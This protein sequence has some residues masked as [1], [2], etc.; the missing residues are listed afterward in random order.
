MAGQTG[1][2]PINVLF[3][4]EG[5]DARSLMAEAILNREG[6]G[7]FVGFSA[8]PD[9]K[10][11][12]NEHAAAVL[13]SVNYKVDALKPKSWE[14]F[15][16]PEAPRMGFVFSLDERIRPESEPAWPGD[17]LCAV[18]AIP[19][20]V[21]ADGSLANVGLAYADAFRMINNRI[22]LFLNLPHASIDR[23]GLQERLNEIGGHRVASGAL[24][25]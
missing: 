17:P 20:P 7:R 4:S 2:A 21:A 12:L 18:W 1:E 14:Q 8:G 24:G 19:D 5:N 15:L 23:L 11:T 13:A 6:R 3:L 10:P 25:G 9:P 16:D 22:D